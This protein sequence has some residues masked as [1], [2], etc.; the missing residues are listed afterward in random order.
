M[1]DEKGFKRKRYADLII[2][3]EPK[4][5]EVYGETVNTS[6]RSALGIILRIFA[7]FLG[8][9][10]ERAEDVYFSAYINTAQGIQQ[11]R[12]GPYVGIT[13]IPEQFA[14]GLVNF[15]GTAGHTIPAGFAVRTPTGVYFTT[16]SGITLDAGGL[17][18]AEVRASAAGVRGNV[19]SGAIS[20]IVN[21]NPNVTDVSN[22][23]VTAGG[24]EKETDLEF[25]ERFQLSVSGGGASTLDSIR[26]ALLRVP[27][28]RAAAVI[29]NTSMITDGAGRPGKSF[30]AYLLGGDPDAI[31]QGILDTKPVGIEAYGD[32]VRTVNDIS[33][34]PHAIK[35]SFAEEVSIK[36]NA[37]ITRND[38]YSADG[39]A[40]I[41]TA[42]IRYI[43]GQ[44]ADGSIYSGLGMGDDVIFS[45]LI[46]AIY[47]VEGVED[48]N[49]EVATTGSYSPGNIGIES[50]SVAQAIH[51]DI[52]VVS[53]D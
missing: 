15:T 40:Q 3:M 53:H 36:V 44:D 34:T 42:I 39:D 23:S 30:Q 7:W 6:E 12:L 33:G 2:E 46:N 16:I 48:V 9:P 25:R 17:G 22:P 35:F 8:K 52:E 31:A 27:G 47:R 28:V 21:P 10:W 43:G 14:A 41:R 11:D 26:S 19:A 5:R 18:M 20:E 37:D 49:L 51:S 38:K 24:R 1:L 50:N 45:R 4:A 29:E 13:R 32:V